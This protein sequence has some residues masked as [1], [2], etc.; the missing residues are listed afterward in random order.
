MPT[1]VLKCTNG[2]RFDKFLPLENYNDTQV[3]DCGAEAKR[4]TV[5]TMISPDIAN[6]DRYL[7]PATG[8]LITSHKERR[9]D[10]KRSGCVDYEPTLKDE[11]KKSHRNDELKLEKDLDNTV[12]SIFSQMPSQKREMLE[13]ELSSGVDLEYTRGTTE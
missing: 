13:R 6:W 9:E 4:I 11:V 1:Y 10:M 7:S 8:K 5:P 2:H 12:E 3:C